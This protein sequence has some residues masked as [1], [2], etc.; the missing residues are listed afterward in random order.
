MAYDV[1]VENEKIKAPWLS[2]QAAACQWVAESDWVYAIVHL[3]RFV[4]LL[5]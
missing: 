4:C 2:G 1:L 3:A 5:R